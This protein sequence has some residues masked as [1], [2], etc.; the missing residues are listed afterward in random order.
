[1][2]PRRMAVRKE[3]KVSR[4]QLAQKVKPTL[5]I[6]RQQKHLK[7]KEQQIQNRQK[8]QIQ[9]RQKQQKQRSLRRI[10][11]RGMFP[12]SLNGRRWAEE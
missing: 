4:K 3:Q 2:Q 1:M 9:N 10:R 11:N 8:Q 6:H 5:L 7:Q 12:Q